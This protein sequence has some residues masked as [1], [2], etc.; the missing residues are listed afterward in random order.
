MWGDGIVEA[1]FRAIRLS[2]V[3]KIT[4]SMDKVAIQEK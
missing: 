2:A 1:S 3:D 4:G